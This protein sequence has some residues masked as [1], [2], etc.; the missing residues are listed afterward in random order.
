MTRWISHFAFGL[1]LGLFSL[2]G[3]AQ[4]FSNPN[5]TGQLLLYPL[6]TTSRNNDTYISVVN[7]TADYKAINVRFLEAMNGQ[8]TLSFYI[9]LAPH[10][11]WASV[12]SDDFSIDS[13]ALITADT[14][15]TIP[16]LI[17][18]KAAGTLGERV[19]LTPEKYRDNGPE[20]DE[21]HKDAERTMVGHIEIIEMGTF[22]YEKVGG[23]DD[24][25]DNH[26][27][28]GQDFSID[29][30]KAIT[31][32]KH[33][34]NH[35]Y[36][37]GSPPN[38]CAALESA[39]QATDRK[40][41]SIDSPEGAFYYAK[42]EHGAGDFSSAAIPLA[43]PTGGLYGYGIIINVSEATAIQYSATAIDG[44]MSGSYHPHP[45]GDEPGIDDGVPS[46]LIENSKGLNSIFLAGSMA[47]ADFQSNSEAKTAVAGNQ[48][49]LIHVD[50]TPG[51]TA[52]HLAGGGQI[53]SAIRESTHSD[54]FSHY[55][56]TRN[57]NSFT[58]V[59]SG[60]TLKG[61]PGSKEALS[62]LLSR[63]SV[64][65]DYVLEPALNAATDWVITL[66]TKRDFV[67]LAQIG[68]TGAE[69]HRFAQAPFSSL[70]DHS[71]TNSCDHVA[72]NYYGREQQQDALLAS[73]DLG[74][75]T[76]DS[77]ASLCFQTNLFSLSND[78]PDSS[79]DLLLNSSTL[80]YMYKKVTLTRG[81]E[82]G[83][84]E[85]NLDHDQL[86]SDNQREALIGRSGTAGQVTAGV[87]TLSVKGLPAIGF[88]IQK[89]IN[90]SATSAGAIANYAISKP[91]QGSRNISHDIS[92]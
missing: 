85:F 14:S 2:P 33:S 68:E 81:F 10:D 42:P 86:K 36:G 58:E 54:N 3:S 84:L 79:T 82:N 50:R 73:G 8:S 7:T 39:W 64:S 66:P 67:N 4:M 88:A 12:V 56:D 35:R 13:T 63:S 44:F 69:Q 89:Y 31:A 28:T 83:W 21:Q 18:S 61:L 47:E 27:V 22:N 57:K 24:L 32:L 70:W 75:A 53:I 19:L 76:N 72:A 9:Y 59:I 87:K 80:G 65:N 55:G 91:H 45:G 6:Y 46:A 43:A 23:G 38:D 49:S 51:K 26:P 1:A 30:Q 29:N 25:V 41:E 20:A 92:K 71:N 60:K 74:S 17:A 62:A 37:Y 15:C 77:Q 90:N 16:N 11:H 78:E 48:V 5:N 40:A 52:S 34:M